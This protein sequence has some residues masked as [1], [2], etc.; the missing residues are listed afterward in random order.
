M[1][2]TGETQ[3]LTTFTTRS[4][5]NRQLGRRRGDRLV[6]ASAASQRGIEQAVAASRS[7]HPTCIIG[8]SGTGKAFLARAIHAWSKRAEEPFVERTC[9]ALPDALQMREIFG[10]AANVH[11]RVPD[12]YEGA[13]AQAGQG[14]LLLIGVDRLRADV[15]NAFIQAL[16]DGGFHREGESARIPLRA[17]VIVTSE[18]PDFTKALGSLPHH[19]IELAP[20][21]E[22]SEDVLPL[23]AH[24]LSACAEETG[25]KFAGFTEEARTALLDEEW[26]GNL[27]E[28]R[29]RIRQAVRLSGGGAITAESLLLARDGAEVPSF[30]DAKRA[31]ETRYVVGLLRRC[32]G[33]I[34]RAAR[35]AK[36]D[37]KDFYDVIRRTGVDPTE[38][39]R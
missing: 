24:F 6:G 8:A 38:F 4:G 36:K 9:S 13:L 29:E 33:N 3:D 18:S 31:F 10:C 30:K 34:S 12:A 21:T 16:N 28:L 11:P 27:R 15:R 7:D 22:R 20:L 37:R 2:A 5:T 32:R 39:R 23:A 19:A 35:L 17:R 25:L 14:S 26:S 1:G